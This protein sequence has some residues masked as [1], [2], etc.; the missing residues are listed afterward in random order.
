M[1]LDALSASQLAMDID[2]LKLQAISNNVANINT[3]GFK[4]ETLEQIQFNELIQPS[5]TQA[6]Q[7]VQ[8]EEIRTQGTLSQT[9]NP[10]DL[11]LSG[12]G[13]FQVQG[14]QG[15]YYTRRGDFH[16]NIANVQ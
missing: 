3:P 13:Y 6:M 1:M 8:K 2:Q 5:T 4:K 16:L 14:E 11:A 15:V 10:K 7:Q 12:S 9:N